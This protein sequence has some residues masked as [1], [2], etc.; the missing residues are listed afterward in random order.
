MIQVLDHYSP[1]DT[2]EYDPGVS[3]VESRIRGR[4]LEKRT[5]LFSLK[6]VEREQLGAG[7]SRGPGIPPQLGSR[8][9]LACV[10]IG[11]VPPLLESGCGVPLAARS[12]GIFVASY[13]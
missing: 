11:P 7:L 4:P 9:R 8:L 1:Q 2:W 10:F 3:W 5:V 12:D 13:W 6:E